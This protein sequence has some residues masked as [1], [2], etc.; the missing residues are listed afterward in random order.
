MVIKTSQLFL[1]HLQI[2]LV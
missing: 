2:R 1:I